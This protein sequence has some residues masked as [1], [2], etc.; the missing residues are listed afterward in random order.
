MSAL[1]CR[2]SGL[3]ISDRLDGNRWFRGVARDVARGFWGFPPD[4]NERPC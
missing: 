2:A 3:A 1:A 4:S